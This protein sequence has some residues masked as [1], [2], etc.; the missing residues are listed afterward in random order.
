MNGGAITPA[1][2]PE[3]WNSGTVEQESAHQGVAGSFSLGG[4]W[5]A[6]GQHLG[7]GLQLGRLVEATLG[8]CDVCGGTVSQRDD[9]TEAAVMRRL[10][11]YHTATM[12]ILDF[13]RGLDRL[14]EIDGMGTGD[15][16][17]SRVSAA[18][19]TRIGV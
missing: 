17:F 11:L 7:S 8:V 13:Y 14:V 4:I 18:V 10:E 2:Q 5:A 9:D 3:Q 6:F 16:V 15:E 1:K 19:D 12:P